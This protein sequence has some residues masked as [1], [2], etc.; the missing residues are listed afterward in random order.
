M[1]APGY[2]TV[3][4]VQARLTRA[5]MSVPA[6]AIG[7]HLA[8]AIEEWERRTGFYPF[9]ALTSA[10][11]R[12][13]TPQSGGTMTLDLGT[14][15]VEIVSVTNYG[16]QLQQDVDWY[17]APDNARADGW[18]YLTIEFAFYITLTQ[19]RNSIV[20]NARWGFCDTLPGDVVDAI[21]N[22]AALMAST[23][24]RNQQLQ[25]AT[26]IVTRETVGDSTIEYGNGVTERMA[27][28]EMWDAHWEKTIRRYKL[29]R[30]A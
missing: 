24:Y 4:E 16:V 29:M 20:V 7:P 26:G 23:A 22:R 5:G 6:Q 9:L 14:G 8:D 18:P 30:L 25:T 21:A 28:S 10:T 13:Y 17:A 11:D 1:S 19:K 27:L 15:A 3:F 12:M 2:P